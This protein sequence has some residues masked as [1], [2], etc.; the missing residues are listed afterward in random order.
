M[1]RKL[2]LSQFR[3]DDDDESAFP[4]AVSPVSF[5]NSVPLANDQKRL[6]LNALKSR[7]FSHGITKKS[8]RDIEREADERKKKEEEE[9]EL[10]PKGCADGADGIGRPQRL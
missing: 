9:Y 1:S 3:G 10:Q 5:V 6:E 7:T 8:K 4:P 2:D